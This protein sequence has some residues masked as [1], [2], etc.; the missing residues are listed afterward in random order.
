MSSLQTDYLNLDSSSVFGRDSERAHAFQ[1]E[2]TFFGGVNQSAEQ[3]FKKVRKEKEKACAVDVLSYRQI[4]R[5]PRKCFRCGYEDHMIAK[6][7]K[8]VCFNEKVN[9]ACNNV[10][11]YSDS[12]IY[13]SMARLSSN[14]EWK[15]NGKTEK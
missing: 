10:K 15:N 8:Q 4:Q 2:C 13:A 14:D 7:P 3:C 1:T 6:C 5:T 9:H 12:K 11:N